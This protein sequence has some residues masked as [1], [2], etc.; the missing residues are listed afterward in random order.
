M[1]R[2][3]DELTA[4]IDARDQA[5]AGNAV[6]DAAQSTL[7][8]KLRHRPPTEIDFARFEL[9]ARQI[10]VDVAADHVGGV[11]GDVATLEWIRDRF[12]DTLDSADLVRIDTHLVE[13]RDSV[14]F[15]SEDLAAARSEAASL[16]D[17]LAGVSSAR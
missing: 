2:A 1:S 7:D 8:L 3:L 5:Q 14:A 15:G 9:W 11:R 12:D 13:L 17:T 16:R 6:I 4:G 10:L